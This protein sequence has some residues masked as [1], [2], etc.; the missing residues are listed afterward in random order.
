MR[1]VLIR[2]YVTLMTVDENRCIARG[3]FFRFPHEEEKV[4]KRLSKDPIPL[5]GASAS[6][7]SQGGELNSQDSLLGCNTGLLLL[8]RLEETKKKKRNIDRMLSK[9]SIYF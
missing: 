6:H 8:E 7:F 4:E 5:R 9:F 1:L 3:V 2:S